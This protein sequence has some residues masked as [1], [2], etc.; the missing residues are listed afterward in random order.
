M[1]GERTFVFSKLTFFDPMSF[2][3]DVPSPV[4]ELINDVGGVE[5]M[6]KFRQ[7]TMFGIK[8]MYPSATFPEE[9]SGQYLVT[10]NM[11]DS[12]RFGSVHL[13]YMVA[14]LATNYDTDY[15]FRLKMPFRRFGR[16]GFTTNSFTAHFDPYDGPVPPAPPGGWPSPPPPLPR[17]PPPPA[18]D[19]VPPNAR[20]RPP[21]PAYDDVPPNARP[22]DKYKVQA[23][24]T[25][26]DSMGI[27]TKQEFRKW[28]VLH[29][30]DKTGNVMSDEEKNV[31][32]CGM[33]VFS[34]K[35]LGGRRKTK[36]RRSQKR[37]TRKRRA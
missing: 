29:H 18:Y 12:K 7:D 30:P 36:K 19:D 28:A 11:N 26:L 20:S 10:L 25:K 34:N 8:N 1:A 24:K 4:S 22:T 13:I 2:P 35:E 33:A 9:P 23:C 32:A 27:K 31:L 16:T 6:R 5:A 15:Y 21:P 17:R 37:A 14:Q 3:R